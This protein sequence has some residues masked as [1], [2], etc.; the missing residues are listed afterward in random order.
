MSSMTEDTAS[1][2]V[3]LLSL[4]S[5]DSESPP[6]PPR[7]PQWRPQP[8]PL[9]PEPMRLS[10]SARDRIL[11]ESLTAACFVLWSSIVTSITS[12]FYCTFGIKVLASPASPEFLIFNQNGIAPILVGST[13]LGLIPGGAAHAVWVAILLYGGPLATG[14]RGWSRGNHPL[15]PLLT[16][17]SILAG[18]FAPA[19]GVAVYPEHLV[20][21]GFTAL[22]ALQVAGV[23]FGVVVVG[24]VLIALICGLVARQT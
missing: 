11:H 12:L 16:L 10:T 8:E 20:P 14:Q 6:S 24:I 5:P 3:L 19:L 21:S 7:V 22:Q 23:G 1:E 4:P 2:T 15:T 9:A 17:I 13:I 18:V